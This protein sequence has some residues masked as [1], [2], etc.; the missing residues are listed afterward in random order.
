MN[1]LYVSHTHPPENTFAD[2]IGGMQ[3]VSFQLIKELRKNDGINIFNETINASGTFSRL[4]TIFFLLKNM[5]LLPQKVKKT[6][7][8]IIL[9]ASATTAILAGVIAKRVPLPMIAITHGR[10]VVLSNPAYQK[11]V[12]KALSSLDGVISISKAT[13]SECLKRGMD[14]ANGVVVPNGIDVSKF[15]NLPD[16]KT[17]RNSLLDKF[18]IPSSGKILLTVGRLEKRKGHEWFLRN[19]LPRISSDVAY[20]V[21]GDGPQSNQLRNTIKEMKLNDQVHLLGSQPDGIVNI[22]YAASDV[23]VMPNIPVEGDMEG[24]GIVLLEANL[25]GTPAVASDLEGIKDVVT[26]G[27]NGF[28]TPVLDAEK[29]TQKINELIDGELHSISLKSKSFIIENFSWKIISKQYLSFL[30][31]YFKA[32]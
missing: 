14:A 5:L 20:V 1:I 16:K 22:A 13:Q 17:A 24:F 23:F 21:I 4:Q 26:D 29:F 12:Q 2:N 19:V 32:N 30:E 28:K 31:R 8:D 25:A 3:R 9:F 10:D 15:N 6:N 11:L 18:G 27:M 7:S